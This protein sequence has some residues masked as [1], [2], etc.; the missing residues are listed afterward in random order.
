MVRFPHPS[1]VV[2]NSFSAQLFADPRDPRP[3]DRR[4][5]EELKAVALSRICALSGIVLLAAGCVHRDGDV[6]R[7]PEEWRSEYASQIDALVLQFRE[8]YVKSKAAWASMGA[9][10]GS[11]AATMKPKP[12]ETVLVGLYLHGVWDSSPSTTLTT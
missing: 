10:P 6:A 12:R 8:C 9:R 7:T 2:P 1:A 11:V 4:R 3:R 5:S